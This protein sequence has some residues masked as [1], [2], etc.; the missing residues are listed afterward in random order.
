MRHDLGDRGFTLIETLVAIGLFA[1]VSVSIY[2][3]LWAGIRV[4][5]TS[6]DVVRISEEARLGL[7]RMIRDTRE[8][9]LFTDLDPTSYS[10]RIDFDGDGLT[11]ENPNENGDYENLEFK[12]RSS[13]STIRLNNEILAAGVEKIGATPVFSY[14]SNDLRYDW[15]GDGVTTSTELDAAPAHGFPAVTGSSALLYDNVEYA[16]QV[17]SGDRLTQFHAQ[18]QLRNR[19]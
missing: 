8:G 16:F 9:Q 17:R 1:I 6:G 15:D 19:R 3:V 13:D 4:S 5:D 12:Y 11:N 7:N 2:S 14:T 18:A 10:V